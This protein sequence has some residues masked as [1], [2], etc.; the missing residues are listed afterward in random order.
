MTNADRRKICAGNRFHPFPCDEVVMTFVEEAEL[1]SFFALYTGE[2]A[3]YIHTP[4]RA[5]C[6]MSTLNEYRSCLNELAAATPRKKA[7]LI[8]SLLPSI[9][10][11]LSSGQTLKD[12]WVALE[13]KGLG[14]AYRVFQMTV[15]RAR[16]SKKTTAPRDW[17]KVNVS[18]PQEPLQQ[19]EPLNVEG[20]D[21]LAN[22]RRLEENRP[23][24][25]WRGT[26]SQRTVMNRREGVNDKGKR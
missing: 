25:H 2:P 20:R 24:F 17:E 9:E 21:P 1:R 8:R 10:A 3:C 19:S 18:S 6:H 23:G 12:I 11:A 13:K 7:A 26:N 15:W 22:L 14:M 4:Y 5:T 16:R